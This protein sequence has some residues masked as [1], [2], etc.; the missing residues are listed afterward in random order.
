MAQ[1]S[2]GKVGALNSTVE[3]DRL[4]AIFGEEGDGDAGH[5]SII[6]CAH[7]HAT[8]FRLRGQVTFVIKGDLRR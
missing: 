6:L 1:Y 4:F 7:C 2:T 3:D 8:N 5:N